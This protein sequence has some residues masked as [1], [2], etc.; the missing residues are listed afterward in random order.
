MLA[1]LRFA[2]CCYLFSQAARSPRAQVKPWSQK[3]EPSTW[4]DPPIQTYNDDVGPSGKGAN[5]K[6]KWGVF[7]SK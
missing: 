2:F 1:S 5:R 3:T 4:P 7:E 6:M